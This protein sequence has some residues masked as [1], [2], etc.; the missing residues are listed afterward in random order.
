VVLGGALVL[1]WMVRA[2][3][4]CGA[5]I[6]NNSNAANLYYGNNPWTPLYKTWYFGTT[7]KLNSPEIRNY[8]EYEQVLQ[9][10]ASLPNLEKSVYLK[11]Q[12]V[13]YIER[14]PDMFALRTL[15]RVRCFFGFDTFTS[16]NLRG[17]GAW[18]RRLFPLSLALEAL[19][20]MAVAGPAF[21]WLA[22]AP[23]QFWVGWQ[24]WISWLISGSIAV[25]AAP[26]WL[27]MSHPTYHYPIMMPL[28]IL[29]V[30]AWQASDGGPGAA[31]RSKLR[32][33]IAVAVLCAI[34]VEWVWQ[35]AGSLRR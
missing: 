33:W 18:G 4:L 19:L 6:I 16:T 7:A 35:M 34:Q 15:N 5:W 23:G 27:S 28:A 10:V 17:D 30:M 31:A 20:Y 14:R 21:F 29:G 9:H 1:G 13:Q 8:P 11:Q 25:Y 32:G 22:A 12:A 26:Y 3:E 24:S 2:H